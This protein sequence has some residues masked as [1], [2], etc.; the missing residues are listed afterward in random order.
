[1]NPEC[2]KERLQTTA[3][4]RKAK[5]VMVIGGGVGGMEAARAV[6]LQGHHVELYETASR[7]GGHLLPA[8]VP[9]FN[10]D[11]GRL[12]DWYEDQLIAGGVTINC[13]T[14]VTPEMVRAK[15]PDAVVVATGSKPLR[16]D[17]PGAEGRNVTTCT[18]LLLGKG[19]CG[20]RVVV[21]GGGLVGCQVALWLAQQGRK[22]TVVEGLPEISTG[23]FEANEDMLLEMLERE[24]VIFLNG[25][26][27]RGITQEGIIVTDDVYKT[28]SVKCDTLVLALGFEPQ[29]DLYEILRMEIPETYAVGDVKRPGN[30]QEA[31]WD[32]FHAGQAICA[33]AS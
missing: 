13:G 18:D 5:D 16:P 26:R 23:G 19:K 17:I 10:R 33:R 25:M 15:V 9:L 1:V 4:A 3:Y 27:I 12:R 21:A 20:N 8:A 14:E 22:I 31:I 2:G 11:L 30:I 29:R 6:A 7:I 32:G 24:D 28:V